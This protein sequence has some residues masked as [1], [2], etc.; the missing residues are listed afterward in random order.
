MKFK[1]QKWK[2]HL[3]VFHRA[4]A[5]MSVGSRLWR[6]CRGRVSVCFKQNH[7]P[8]SKGWTKLSPQ[9]ASLYEYFHLYD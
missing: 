5:I 8:S 9:R 4:L 7:A 3:E 2:T 1:L 6:S